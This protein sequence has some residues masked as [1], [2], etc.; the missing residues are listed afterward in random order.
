[1][2][3]TSIER[4]RRERLLQLVDVAQAYRGCT[5]AE[6]AS[7]LD[8]D[9]AKIAPDSGNPKLDL[10]FNLADVIDWP[11]G[12]LAEM[13]W[14]PHRSRVNGHHKR[15]RIEGTFRELDLRAREAAR[16]GDYAEMRWLAEQMFDMATTPLERAGAMMRIGNAWIGDG[17]YTKALEWLQMAS[18]EV[19]VPA[20]I[21]R[22]VRVN[23]ASAHLALW[24]LA[25]AEALG[26]LLMEDAPPTSPEDRRARV[27]RAHAGFVVGVARQR[28]VES[29]LG[30]GRAEPAR[31]ALRVLIPARDEY[32]ELHRLHGDPNYE[33]IANTCRAAILEMEVEAGCRAPEEALRE[34]EAGLDGIVDPAA[35]RGDLLESWGWW[36]VSGLSL[37]LRHLSGDDRQR[38][39]AIFSNKAFELAE[40]TGSWPLRERA[41]CLGHLLSQVEAPGARAADVAPTLDEEDLRVLVGTMGRFPRFRPTGWAIM[42]QIM[43]GCG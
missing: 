38:A 1:M 30:D 28:R 15:P 40:A 32:L 39:A 11:I 24:N 29:M 2:N 8:R 36:C 31:A 5:R 26:L 43:K 14:G 13:L 35:V 42:E 20:H 25:E 41:F 33:G 34:F 10:L 6:L 19:D 17:R 18:A 3:A 7:F 21:C 16:R 12:D 23:L 22:M 9:P 4:G 37:A 27:V